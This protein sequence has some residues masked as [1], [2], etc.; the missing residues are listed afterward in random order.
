MKKNLLNL[1]LLFALATCQIHS[2][3]SE[4]QDNHQPKKI[5]DGA[6]AGYDFVI[7]GNLLSFHDVQLGGGTDGGSEPATL[8]TALGTDIQLNTATSVASPC[9]TSIGS[10]EKGGDISLL[11]SNNK[12][13]KILAGNNTASGT[14]Y[15]NALPVDNS[16]VTGDTFIGSGL[17]KV[18]IGSGYG[19][20]FIGG[21]GSF[22]GTTPTN[23]I[24]IGTYTNEAGE[25]SGKISIGSSDS[26]T[27]INGPTIVGGNMND[28]LATSYTTYESV[29]VAGSNINRVTNADADHAV[30]L[31][32]ITLLNTDLPANLAVGAGP[33]KTYSNIVAINATLPSSPTD[34]S[35]YIGGNLYVTNINASGTGDTIIGNSSGGDITINRG[36]SKDIIITGLTQDDTLANGIGIDSNGKLFKTLNS[37]INWANLPSPVTAKKNVTSVLIDAATGTVYKADSGVG[38]QLLDTEDYTGVVTINTAAPTTPET[39]EVYIGGSNIYLTSGSSKELNIKGGN[40]GFVYINCATDVTSITAETKIGLGTGKTSIALGNGDLQLGGTSLGSSF[41]GDTPVNT[42]YLGAASIDANTKYQGKISIG[43]PLSCT[44]MSGP[45]IVGG[46]MNDLAATTYTTYDG[47]FVVGGNIN[48]IANASA[49]HTVVLEGI[50]IF[51]GGIP[52]TVD[53]DNGAQPSKTFS[54]IIVLNQNLPNSPLNN[55]TYIGGNT[56]ISGDEMNINSRKVYITGGD[57]GVKINS[58]GDAITSIGEGTGAVN[59]GNGSSGGSNPINIGPSNYGGVITIGNSTAATAPTVSII[60]SIGI[61]GDITLTAGPTQN[62]IFDGLDNPGNGTIVYPIVID[63]NGIIYK[64]DSTASINFKNL[65]KPSSGT[66]WD[67]AIDEDGNIHKKGSSSAK[68]KRNIERLSDEA[69]SQIYSLEAVQYNIDGYDDVEY[70]FIA[71][72]LDQSNT[73]VNTVRYSKKNN[74]PLMIHYQSIFVAAV[75]ELSKVKNQLDSLSIEYISLNG[76]Y[77]NL[78][79]EF[80]ELKEKYSSL[81][82]LIET[83]SAKIQSMEQN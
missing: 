44:V 54:N 17:G 80:F 59:I 63:Q 23:S 25:Y 21:P 13:I 2:K 18:T 83:L 66:L 78:K 60:G 14:V 62:I 43:T 22:R 61:T 32:G 64:T 76:D 29:F 68:V 28:T 70:G 41:R 36:S 74:A 8:I 15:I 4:L 27:V 56:Y 19:D 48:A 7:N 34:G 24:F 38:L 71:E 47:V 16:S 46:I 82:K 30:T 77:Q 37:G 26:C 9:N 49:E 40:G 81:T 12:S 55:S 5:G 57:Q 42:I 75:K 33:S 11:A 1:S 67:L 73:M 6:A 39:N 45:T 58:T 53:A 10:T 51:N 65:E 69:S 50:A 3:T 20:V 79:K 31:H 52:T 72:N 35:T